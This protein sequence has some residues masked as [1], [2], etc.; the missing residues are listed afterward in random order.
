[1][2][3]VYSNCT[4]L[5][6]QSFVTVFVALLAGGGGERGGGK[7]KKKNGNRSTRKTR[8]AVVVAEPGLRIRRIIHFRDCNAGIN[9]QP[10]TA[11]YGWRI[12][13]VRD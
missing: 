4:D 10:G 7:K 3:L 1:M 2:G 11:G 12:L 9:R 8:I 5:I 13:Y 6:V